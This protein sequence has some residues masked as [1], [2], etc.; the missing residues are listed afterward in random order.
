[1]GYDPNRIVRI[2]DECSCGGKLWARYDWNIVCDSCTY[3]RHIPEN[4]A[5]NTFFVGGTKMSGLYVECLDDFLT[6]T[7]ISMPRSIL[8][9]GDL[10]S[11]V[12]D[13]ISALRSVYT[14]VT[15]SGRMY[16][17][18]WGHRW[19]WM[20]EKIIVDILRDGYLPLHSCPLYPHVLESI[21]EKRDRYEASLDA[22]DLS[23]HIRRLEGC[24]CSRLSARDAICT[25]NCCLWECK[26]HNPAF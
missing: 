25:C 20:W 14:D 8:P 22:L 3:V 23:R 13:D 17:A 11:R 4:G 9:P 19:N 7:N 24:D 18:S 16:W 10:V 12:S 21:L 2:N 6:K 15:R 26:V 5:T 1:M